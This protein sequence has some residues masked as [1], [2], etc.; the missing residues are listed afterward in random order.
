MEH[1][2]DLVD[3]GRVSVRPM[4][5]HTFA[6]EEWRRALFAIATQGETGA[7]KVAFDHRPQPGAGTG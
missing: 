3:E 5:T 1:Y 2:F 6:L 7:V 4:L